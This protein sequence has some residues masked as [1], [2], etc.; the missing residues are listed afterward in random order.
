M[1]S[2]MQFFHQLDEKIAETFLAQ[3]HREE[4]HIIFLSNSNSVRHRPRRYHDKFYEH[5]VTDN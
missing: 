2:K 3:I 4:L 1:S 5:A